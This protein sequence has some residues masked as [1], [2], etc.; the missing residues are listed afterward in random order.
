MTSQNNQLNYRKQQIKHQNIYIKDPFLSPNDKRTDKQL[1]IN[2]TITKV[3]L[4]WKPMKQK[5]FYQNTIIKALDLYP[6]PVA[7]WEE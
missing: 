7:L 1:Y 4:S 2:Q 3:T 5:L 6:P